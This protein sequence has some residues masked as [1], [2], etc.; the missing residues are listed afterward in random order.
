MPSHQLSKVASLS[1]FFTVIL[2]TTRDHNPNFITTLYIS[3][4]Q[5][6]PKRM[7]LLVYGEFS[8]TFLVACLSVGGWQL[9]TC[10]VLYSPSSQILP[11]LESATLLMLSLSRICNALNAF[12]LLLFP[13][14]SLLFLVFCTCLVV[15]EPLYYKTTISPTFPKFV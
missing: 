11:S 12:S 14:Y 10:S 7:F 15:Q 2:T 1:T 5:P 9:Q 8:C 3:S 13:R 4:V 6:L